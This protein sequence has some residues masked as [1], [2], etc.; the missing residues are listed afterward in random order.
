MARHHHIRYRKS[1][2]Q[3]A[4]VQWCCCE[5]ASWRIGELVSKNF[6]VYCIH[7]KFLTFLD[8]LLSLQGLL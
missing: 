6:K 4:M 8:F 5:L 1:F 3:G 7:N 2:L